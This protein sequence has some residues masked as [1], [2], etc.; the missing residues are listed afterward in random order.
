MELT[1]EDI[2]TLESMFIVEM[3]SAERSHSKAAHEA[4]QADALQRFKAKHPAPT[5][6]YFTKPRGAFYE[7]GGIDSE[8]H[9]PSSRL[10]D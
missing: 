4:R 10:S 1:I 9:L 6:S 7:K 5:N 2:K 8:I 3:H